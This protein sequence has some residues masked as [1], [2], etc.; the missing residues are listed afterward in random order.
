[1]SFI[2]CQSALQLEKTLETMKL[3]YAFI[4][5]DHRIYMEMKV[6]DD[7]VY[8]DLDARTLGCLLELQNH[9]EWMTEGF[10]ETDILDLENAAKEFSEQIRKTLAAVKFKPRPEKVKK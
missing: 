2:Q 4:T 6:S 8:Y 7:G 1:M 9:M 3:P 5:E 10:M